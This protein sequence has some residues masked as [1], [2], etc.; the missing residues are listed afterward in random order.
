MIKT[1]ESLTHDFGGN[2]FIDIGGNVGMWTAELVDLYDSVMFVEPS[3]IAMSKAKDRIQQK[4][5]ELGIS[6]SRVQFFKNV[7]S[8]QP[9]TVTIQ[10]STEDSGNFTMFGA[11]LYGDTDVVMSESDIPAI[12]L[13]SFMDQIK[14]GDRVLIKV[15]TEGADIDVLLS[16]QNLIRRFRPE[17]FLEVHYHMHCD[18]DKVALLSDLLSELDYD[19]VEFKFPDYLANRYRVYG[20]HTGEQMYDL[21]YHIFCKPTKNTTL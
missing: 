4:C 15:D 18:S 14:E 9:G 12:T 20:S 8:T 2:V 17:I 19:C 11:E 3:S 10:S 7:V 5:S 16:G 6:S 1:L 13:D 21:H